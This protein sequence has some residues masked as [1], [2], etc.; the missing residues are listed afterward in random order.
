M[1][2]FENQKLDTNLIL[3]Y[4]GCDRKL[5]EAVLCG[6]EDLELSTNNYDW[7]GPGIYFWEKNPHRAYE[8][9]CEKKK[10]EQKHHEIDPFVI[11]AVFTLENCLDTMNSESLNFLRS[12]FELLQRL[13]NKYKQELPKNSTD[14][15]SLRRNLDCAVI[16]TLHY[17]INQLNNSDEKD[18]S[19][20]EFRPIDSVRGLFFEG[21]DLYENSGFR[22]KTHVQ[23]AICRPENCIKGIFRVDQEQFVK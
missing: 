8:F 17:S 4:H 1:N 11:G 18:G 13:S 2:N 16:N 5:G 10:R 21:D 9:I 7:L 20:K 23:I 14:K 22:D 15:N 19:E 12:G 6:D 3:G